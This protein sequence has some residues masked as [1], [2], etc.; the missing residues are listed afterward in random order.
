MTQTHDPL[1][2]NARL[3]AQVGKLLDSLEKNDK[4]LGL[5]DR[6]AALIAVGRVQTIFVALRKEHKGDG[7]RS[8]SRVKKYASAFKTNVARGRKK[9]AGSAAAAE[10]GDVDFEDDSAA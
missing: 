3:Y 8:G 10:F 7:S 5:K 2:I 6:I 4:N 9:A 1:N